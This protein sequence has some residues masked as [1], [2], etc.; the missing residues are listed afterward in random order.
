MTQLVKKLLPPAILSVF[1]LFTGPAF[2]EIQDWGINFQDAASPSAIRMHEFHTMMLWIISAITLFVFALLL[3][4][5]VRYNRRA[6][7]VPSQT[8][9]NVLLE[10]IWTLVPVIILIAIIIPSFKLLYYTDRTPNAEMTLKVTGYQWYWGYEYPDHGGVNFMAYLVPEKELNKEA[11]Q[12]RLLSTDAP[13][14]L[15]VDTNIR[16]LVTAGDVLHSWAVPQLGVKMD[17]NPGRLNETWVRI[18]KPGTYY[19][20]CSELCGKDHAYMP[21]EIHAVAKEEF[22]AWVA[23]KG[24]TMPGALPASDDP[25]ATSAAPTEGPP[26]QAVS[27]EKTSGGDN[28]D[29]KPATE[30]DVEK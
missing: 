3:W 1:M 23:E 12:K 17:A 30:G 11:G 8:T 21:I 24:G 27:N 10:I 14:I 16:V 18:N 5:I 15:P 7:P 2:A 6:N 4:V 22:A 20:Q 25:S 13:V 9:H 29:I 26:K 19:G 28:A